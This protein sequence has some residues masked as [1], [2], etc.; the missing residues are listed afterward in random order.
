MLREEGCKLVIY[1]KVVKWFGA[2][3]LDCIW[4][5][6]N[7]VVH[8]G[9]VSLEDRM[10][11]SFHKLVQEH[12]RMIRSSQ[13]RGSFRSPSRWSKPSHN[14]FEL[15]CDATVELSFSPILY[16]FQKSERKI[17]FC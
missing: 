15:N 10:S 4:M 11:R 16:V 12:W 2:S 5:W 3:N 6:R 14:S 8:E 17:G 7:K 1:Q 9:L 13:A